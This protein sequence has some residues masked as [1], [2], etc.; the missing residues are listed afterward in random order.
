[1]AIFATGFAGVGQFVKLR[2]GCFTGALSGLNNPPQ[3]TSLV[4][5]LRGGW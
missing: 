2:A 4:A 1:V 5:I 3:A